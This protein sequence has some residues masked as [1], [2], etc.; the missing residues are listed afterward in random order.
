MRTLHPGLKRVVKDLRVRNADI[1]YRK[2]NFAKHLVESMDNKINRR[3]KYD[4]KD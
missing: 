2:E 3:M 4:K 1:C